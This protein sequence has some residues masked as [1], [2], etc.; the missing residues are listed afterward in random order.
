MHLPPMAAVLRAEVPHLLTSVSG[1][2]SRGEKRH[3]MRSV[4]TRLRSFSQKIEQQP[5]TGNQ[6]KSGG[7]L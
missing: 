6:T 5:Q 1:H 3:R 2:H 7:R 4:D